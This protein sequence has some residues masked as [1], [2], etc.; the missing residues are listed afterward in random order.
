MRESVPQGRYSMGDMGV[1]AASD[2]LAAPQDSVREFVPALLA[3]PIAEGQH[4][5]APLLPDALASGPLPFV[6]VSRT[7]LSYPTLHRTGLGA[8]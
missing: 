8:E 6:G 4:I 5:E 1:S 2:S 3:A 7:R